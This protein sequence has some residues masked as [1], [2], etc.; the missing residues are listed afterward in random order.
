MEDLMKRGGLWCLVVLALLSLA[1]MPALAGSKSTTSGLICTVPTLATGASG[2]GSDS[3]TDYSNGTAVKCFL[4]AGGKNFD[5][6]TYSSGRTFT[7]SFASGADQ[8]TAAQASLPATL[9]AEVDA[10]GINYWGQYLNMAIGTTAQ[11]QMDVQFHW[12][13]GTT[14]YEL[15]YSCL[16]VT[17]TA[18]TNWVITSVPDGSNEHAVP[19]LI[20]SGGSK[21]TLSKIRRNSVQGFGEVS[22]PITIE[23]SPKP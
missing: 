21:A 17:R 7:F 4:G 14:T 19:C 22:M 12:G 18:F 10:Y 6:V 8:A 16:A 2:V 5:L 13:G 15:S 3:S 9:N 11:V 23:F 1:A 20:T